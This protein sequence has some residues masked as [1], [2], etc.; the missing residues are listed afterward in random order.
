MIDRRLVKTILAF[1]NSIY[2]VLVG[3]F[4]LW[5]HLRYEKAAIPYFVKRQA[6]WLGMG[7]ATIL[8][9][10]LIDYINFHNWPGIF[11]C[12]IDSVSW[13]I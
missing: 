5:C 2:P 1:V 10:C 11:T 4:V 6:L 9:I 7:F 13:S 12:F 8:F 3:L